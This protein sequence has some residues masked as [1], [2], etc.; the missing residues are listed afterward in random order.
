VKSKVALVLPSR[1]TPHTQRPLGKSGLAL[2]IAACLGLGAC[3][4]VGPTHERPSVAVPDAYKNVSGVWK[5]AQ[6]GDRLPR[7]KWWHIYQDPQ[8]DAL[9][10]RVASGNQSIRQAEARY[11]QAQ[12]LMRQAQADRS[13]F[14]TGGATAAR[15]RSGDGPGGARGSYELDVAAS[16]EPDL[17]GRVRRAVEAG[18]AQAQAAAADLESVRLAV[19]AALVQNYLAVRVL[20][21]QARL[22][23]ETVS[24]YERFLK[25]TQNRYNAGVVGKSDVVQAEAQLKSTQAQRVELGVQRAQL[26]HAIAVLVGETPAAVAIAPAPLV[27]SLPQIPVGLPS[28]LLQR[29]PD[30]ASAERNVAAANAR[31]GVAQSALYPSVTLSAGAGLRS[32]TL[33]DL[34]RAPNLFWALGAAAAQVL[35]DGGTRQAVIDQARAAHDAEVALYRQTVL[36]SFQEVE[37]NL[38]ALRI[39]EEEAALLA[40]AVAASRQSVQLSENR[41]KAGTA[42]FLE[43]ITVRAIALSNERTAVALLGRRFAATVQV[44]RALGGGWE[45]GQ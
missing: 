34:L 30:I 8:L 39:L 35:F 25:L 38:A 29:R 32:A 14:L 9:A 18:E 7:G 2:A 17:W 26:E 42:N 10:E 3:S 1:H 31:I 20:D 33:P 45:A 5:P 19:T 44:V 15:T 43:V 16:W 21:T 6:P 12:A 22:L 41:Y 13:P 40:A 28:E 4:T 11:R 23:D 36:T 24:S 27:A 37:D